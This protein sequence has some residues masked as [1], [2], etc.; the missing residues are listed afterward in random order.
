MRYLDDLY[1]E[2]ILGNTL[3]RINLKGLDKPYYVPDTPACRLLFNIFE[4]FKTVY[5]YIKTTKFYKEYKKELKIC[6][7]NENFDKPGTKLSFTIKS[8]QYRKIIYSNISFKLKNEIQYIKNS[9][10]VSFGNLHTLNGVFLKLL[11]IIIK[12]KEEF[13]EFL[14]YLYDKKEYVKLIEILYEFYNEK[15]KSYIIKSVEEEK[16]KILLGL[17]H[18]RMRN[19]IKI[20]ENIKETKEGKFKN[21]KYHLIISPRDRLS[22]FRGNIS[23]DCTAFK[24]GMAFSDT[25]PQ[26]LLDPGFINMRLYENN[27]WVGNVYLLCGRIDREGTLIIDAIQTAVW[28]NFIFPEY[29]IAR[30]I[31][32][33]IKK[34]A[35]KKGFKHV[36]LS[37]FISNRPMLVARFRL[38]PQRKILFHKIGGFAHLKELNLW[39]EKNFRNEYIETFSPGDYNKPS[40][41]I[42]VRDIEQL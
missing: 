2:S 6:G 15:V 11:N 42:P 30:S 10:Y 5:D 9:L 35:L 16:Q 20:S 38:L 19:L 3:S 33:L 41:I 24:Y 21:L 14:E 27:K 23:S 40:Q 25:I 26:H 36:Y 37:E 39:D 13:V 31:I 32:K 12:S 4:K 34:W 8:R 18:E 7:I 22:I 29:I 1:I 17:T 28:H